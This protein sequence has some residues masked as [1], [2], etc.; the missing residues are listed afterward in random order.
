MTLRGQALYDAMDAT[1]AE[2]RFLHLSHKGTR[3]GVE[4]ETGFL[5]WTVN[6]AQDIV[7]QYCMHMGMVTSCFMKCSNIVCVPG[8]TNTRA[9][10]DSH[11]AASLI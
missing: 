7:E 8:C 1:T 4:S 2:Q 3:A 6:A 10:L 11:E 5:L 9:N